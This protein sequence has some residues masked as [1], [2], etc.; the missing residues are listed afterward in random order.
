MMYLI[1]F[2]YNNKSGHTEVVSATTAQNAIKKAKAYNFLKNV[3]NQNGSIGTASAYK[4]EDDGTYNHLPE[5]YLYCEYSQS[6]KWYA[7]YFE[8]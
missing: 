4:I 3:M 5:A 2:D 7:R 6:G 1:Y 8:N